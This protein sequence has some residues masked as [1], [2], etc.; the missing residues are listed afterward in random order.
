MLAENGLTLGDAQ[1][2]DGGV[3]QG[4]RDAEHEAAA[5][6]AS[7]GDAADSAADQTSVADRPATLSRG[8]LDTFA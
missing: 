7:A 6:I 5:S 2:G 3:Q 4:S 1:V 8:L